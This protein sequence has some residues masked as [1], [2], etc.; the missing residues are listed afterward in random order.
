MSPLQKQALIL[1]VLGCTFIASI[2][3]L[4]RSGKLSFRFVIGWISFGLAI[5]ASSLLLSLVIPISDAVG[6]T[7]A[8]LGLLTS[9]VI[10]VGVAVELSIT[11][12]R[13]QMQIRKL[14]E[15]VSILRERLHR[16]EHE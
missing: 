12:S 10:P 14:A 15:D 6:L 1:A 7:P 2:I 4:G 16:E 13:Q 9:V 11:S 3:L 8:S 5:V